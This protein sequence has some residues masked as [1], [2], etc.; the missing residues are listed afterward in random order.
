M[1]NLKTPLGQ[2][3]DIFPL[4]IIIVYFSHKGIKLKSFYNIKTF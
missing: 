4:K 1:P 3:K 2:K